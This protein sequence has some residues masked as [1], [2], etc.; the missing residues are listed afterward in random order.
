MTP[1]SLLLF[2]KSQRFDTKSTHR[3]PPSPGRAYAWFSSCHSSP[4]VSVH[5]ITKVPSPL[6]THV[7]AC[8]PL[9]AHSQP[10]SQATTC[11]SI[12]IFRTSYEVLGAV[13][14]ECRST[15]T[16]IFHYIRENLMTVGQNY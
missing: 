11:L 10:T 6:L 8:L 5:L 14:G 15:Q 3:N 1:H 16:F 4:S 9:L 12:N 2:S 13:Y 7:N